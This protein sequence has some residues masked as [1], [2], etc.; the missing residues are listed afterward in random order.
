MPIK[1]TYITSDGQMYDTEE[2]AQQREDCY[3][4]AIIAAKIDNQGFTVH[5]LTHLFYNL[6]NAGFVIAQPPS[7]TSNSA[8]Q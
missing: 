4:N 1:P 8:Q 3:N 7:K 5:Q 2:A 6:V